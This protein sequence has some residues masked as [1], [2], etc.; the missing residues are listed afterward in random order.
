M[1]LVELLE[2]N[3]RQFGTYTSLIYE[4]HEYTNADHDEISSRMAHCLAAAGVRPGDRV[5]VTM[6]NRPEVVW[7]YSAI[8]KAG[9]VTVPVMPLLQAAEVRF[10][11]QDAA[12][13]A[14]I[15]AQMLRDKVEQAI[16][17][18]AD[19]PVVWSVDQDGYEAFLERL[20][21]F[22]ATRPDV[23]IQDAQTAVILYTS[24]TTGRP[25]GVT[26]T[27]QNLCANAKAAAELAATY[28][29]NVERR[30]GLAVLPL[31]HAFGF[32][33]MNTALC[34]G[35][36]DVLLPY[37]D[38]VL[39]FQAIERYKVTHFTA[40]PAM[41]HA[42]LHHPDAEKYDLSSLS[43]CISGSAPLPLSL[44]QAFQEKFRCIVF[45][46]YGLSEAAP[47][48]TAPRFDKP[49]KPGSV[50]LPLPGVEVRVVDEQGRPLPPGEVGELAVRGPNVT[51]GYHNLP[52]ET[53][54][55]LKDGWLLTGDMARIDEDG[56]VFIVDRKKDVIIRGGF[57]IYPRDLE[58]L[59]AKHPAVAEVAVVGAPSE[60]MGEE[61]VAFVVKRPKTEVTE[62]EL[63]EYCQQ[64]L[65]KYKTP[66]VVQFVGYLP[67]NLIGKV[68]KK[69]LRA[70]ARRIQL[71]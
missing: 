5:I 8:A 44:L 9:A 25:K 58:E 36:T 34:L 1:N 48:V 56:Y 18:L 62:Q 42:L 38:P 52:E 68:D 20:K 33:M 45:E 3:L 19:P 59:L 53:A 71:S 6:P 37:F 35:E 4:E 43:L 30:V 66:R 26:L 57:N 61:V 67:K 14:I 12:P 46:G 64:H 49:L 21:E 16:E 63:I 60:A 24:G 22:P 28:D 23:A 32:T 17:G 15:T 50:G 70:M 13:K 65:A 7:A 69:Q 51:P 55:V 2:D 29:F 10:I 11:V 39:V 27:H 41:F 47:V 31:S 40:V 54:K